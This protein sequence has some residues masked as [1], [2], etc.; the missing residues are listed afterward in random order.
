MM[1]FHL[2]Y[3][4]Y[5]AAELQLCF[6]FVYEVIKLFCFKSVQLE[7]TVAHSRYAVCSWRLFTC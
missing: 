7:T 1:L 6:S 2:L 5:A 4:L 3:R